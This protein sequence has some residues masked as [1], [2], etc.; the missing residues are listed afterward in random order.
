MMA[1][2]LILLAA[3]LATACGGNIKSLHDEQADN[4]VAHSEGR[5]PEVAR[6]AIEADEAPDGSCS[7]VTAEMGDWREQLFESCHGWDVTNCNHVFLVTSRE[8]HSI[9]RLLYPLRRTNRRQDMEEALAESLA[10]RLGYPADIVTLSFLQAACT[11]E[12]IEAPF[13]GSFL[14]TGG[15]GSTTEMAGK[16]VSPANGQMH[17]LWRLPEAGRARA[18]F[19]SDAGFEAYYPQPWAQVG[20]DNGLGP[21]RTRLEIVSSLPRVQGVV[22]G[23]GQ[24]ELIVDRIDDPQAAERV[25]EL[26]RPMGKYGAILADRLLTSRA[27]SGGCERLREIVVRALNPPSPPEIDHHFLCG[28]NDARFMTTV[29]Y[30]E[31]DPRSHEFR[32][33]GIEV[34]RSISLDD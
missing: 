20:T 9:A 17:I 12:G 30:W 5:A 31:G 26:E 7:T 2:R 3:F 13:V 28:I 14:R 24:A 4:A 15:S 16:I 29:R 27:R 10:A 11:R 8:L 22:I 21:S 25:A 33:A 1:H 19:S 32:R 34:A 23:P 18:R 6:L